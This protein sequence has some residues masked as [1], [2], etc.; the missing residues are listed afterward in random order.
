MGKEPLSAAERECLLVGLDAGPCGAADVAGP[1]CSPLLR[2]LPVGQGAGTDMAEAERTALRL[3]RLRTLYEPCARELAGGLTAL[4][5]VPVDVAVTE[6]E[7][8]SLEQFALEHDQPV[9]LYPLATEDGLAGF[10]VELDSALL[11]PMLNRLLGGGVE[12]APALG[13]PLT[14]IEK[15]LAVRIGGVI[16]RAWERYWDPVR[17]LRW[18]ITRIEDQR[19]LADAGRL[20]EP[21]AWVRLAVA[22][23]SVRGTLRLVLPWAFLDSLDHADWPEPQAPGRIPSEAPAELT[24][25]LAEVELA[26]A[27]LQDL[28]VGDVIPTDKTIDDGVDVKLAGENR[29]RGRPG[30][31]DGHRAVR[32]ESDAGG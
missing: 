15:R 11:V 10:T 13:R 1:A 8:G 14:E 28:Q 21:L 24:V 32:L 12:P 27:D 4:L 3:R 19:F 17:P 29:F 6:V 22:L 16:V 26:A 25:T 7:R 30:V 2:P 18:S 9:C 23:G 31:V 5:R 20:R